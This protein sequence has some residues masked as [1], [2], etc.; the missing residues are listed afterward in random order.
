MVS[1]KIIL[2]VVLVFGILLFA[3]QKEKYKGQRT[4]RSHD[5]SNYPGGDIGGLQ[6]V[7]NT[8]ACQKLCDAQPNTCKGFVVAKKADT[9]QPKNK[10][11]QCYLKKVDAFST[12]NRMRDPNWNSRIESVYYDFWADQLKST[13]GWALGVKVYN[14]DKWSQGMKFYALDPEQKGVKSMDYNITS[15]FPYDDP[16]GATTIEVPKGLT[17][18][19][20]GKPADITSVFDRTKGTEAWTE[21]KP[22]T[23]KITLV[24][25]EMSSDGITAF[26]N[27]QWND[28]VIS[29]RVARA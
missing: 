11:R 3:N 9:T 7:K 19:L 22:M 16:N 4:Y 2:I 10:Q 12:Q 14:D 27:G 17:V 6:W 1:F 18:Q 24:Q 15:D 20:F 8:N 5:N 25:G 21:S 13:G 26:G 29:I 28:R 23:G